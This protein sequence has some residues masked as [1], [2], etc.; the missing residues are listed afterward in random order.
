MKSNGSAIVF[1][2]VDKY[3]FLQ[4]QKT[5]KEFIQA[6]FFKQKTIEKIHALKSVSFLIKEGET[7]GIIGPNGA[8]KS[9]I[10]KLIA[11]VSTP[12]NGQVR[13]FGRITP[14]IE[15]GAG[16]HPE[17]TGRENIFLNGVIL[18]LSEE[19]IKSKVDEIIAFSEINPDFIDMPVKHYSSGMYLRLA[20]SVAVFTQ[21]DILLVDE[22]LAVGDTSF[23]QKC[24]NKMRQFQNQGVT[25]VY[26]SHSMDQVRQFCHRVIYINKGQIKYDGTPSKAIEYYLNDIKTNL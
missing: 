18:G 7:V 10:L 17:L 20:F 9:T 13:V 6:L 12:T 26:I 21:P 23:Q 15:L 8:G 11:G 2:Q 14:L 1:D 5:L 22:I 24:L 25:I 3:F 4:H 16:F 19:Y